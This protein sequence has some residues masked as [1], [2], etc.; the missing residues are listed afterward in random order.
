MSADANKSI[1]RRFYEEAFSQGNLAV[2]AEIADA[3]YVNHD[4][5][6]PPGGWPHGVEG[7][8]MVVGTYRGA[9]PDLRFTVED[10]IAE[11]DRVVT[12]WSARGTNSGS[13]MGM[14]PSGRSATV[15]G[16]SIE[17]IAN[18]KMVETWVNFDTLGM[19]QQL[20]VIPAPGQPG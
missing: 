3:G 7:L 5:S 2:L 4:P 8:N 16:I 20:G 13:L 10:Q 11:G 18:G 12:R 15:T 14:P 9:F 6:G 19:M 17:R 1:V